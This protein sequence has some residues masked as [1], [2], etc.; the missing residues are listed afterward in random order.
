MPI[1]QNQKGVSLL[2]LVAAAAAVAI[3]LWVPAAPVVVAVPAGQ[4][5]LLSPI[6]LIIAPA[7]AR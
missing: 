5:E 2:E 4:A 1:K 3:T 7:T 6:P